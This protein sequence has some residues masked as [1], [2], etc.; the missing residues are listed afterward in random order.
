MKEAIF[1]SSGA[2]RKRRKKYFNQLEIAQANILRENRK[3]EKSRLQQR[4]LSKNDS[5]FQTAANINSYINQ[6]VTEISGRRR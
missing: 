6:I 2:K 3:L 1:M 4:R 5:S